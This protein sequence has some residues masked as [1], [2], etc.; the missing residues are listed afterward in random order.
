[1]SETEPTPWPTEIKLNKVKD[2]LTVA[3]EDGQSFVFTAELL[4]V[5][6]PSAE[7]QG[8]SPGQRVTV[9]GK[10]NVK[11][12]EV[13]RIGNYAVKLHFD[14]RHNTGIFS[15]PYFHR[16]GQTRTEAWSQY[17]AD[18]KRKGLSR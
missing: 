2:E 14:D 16:L 5:M 1:M 18:L 12:L 3:F 17:L 13:E 15:W 6:S 4:R 7:V 10:K 11:I 8:H 9:A